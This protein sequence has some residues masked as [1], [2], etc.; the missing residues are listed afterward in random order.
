MNRELTIKP[1]IYIH[2]LK[3]AK[4]IGS[5]LADPILADDDPKVTSQLVHHPLV[6]SDACF[7]RCRG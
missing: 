2:P 5:N 7:R 1:K 3:G 6:L 4:E